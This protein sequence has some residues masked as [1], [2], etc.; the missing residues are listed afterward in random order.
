MIYISSS[1]KVFRNLGENPIEKRETP[2]QVQYLMGISRNIRGFNKVVPNPQ[3]DT[4]F[5]IFNIKEDPREG[6]LTAEF[7]L[8]VSVKIAEDNNI[9]EYEDI[10]T[11]VRKEGEG[12]PG[13]LQYNYSANKWEVVTPAKIEHL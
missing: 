1:E 7:D 6:G 10:C 5:K 13:K 2:S 8:C 11:E 12:A 9:F 4:F 3:G